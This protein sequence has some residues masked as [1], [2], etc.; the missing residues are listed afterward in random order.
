M[1][2]IDL[3]QHAQEEFEKIKSFLSHSQETA[4]NAGR[5]EELENIL[6]EVEKWGQ[7]NRIISKEIIDV[8]SYGELL[9]YLA[10]LRNPNE[11]K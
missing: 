9:T 8:V 10:S 11:E 3:Q 2:L 7:E 1:T 5:R 6:A 4:W